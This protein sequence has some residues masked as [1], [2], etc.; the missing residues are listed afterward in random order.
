MTPSDATKTGALVHIGYEIEQMIEGIK[1]VGAYPPPHRLENNARLEAMLLHV[2]ILRDF[3]EGKIVSRYQDN[4][5]SEDFGYGPMS[6][7]VPGKFKD[8]LNKQVAHLTYSRVG[9]AY[10]DWPIAEVT[11][12][13]IDQCKLFVR[14]IHAPGYELLKSAPEVR[15][16]WKQLDDDLNSLMLPGD[17]VKGATGPNQPPR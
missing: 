16:Q 3:F 4:V 12:S 10:K 13:L 17:E 8:R 1:L 5:L 15:V 6:D 2:R 11:G 7:V 14:H 9:E